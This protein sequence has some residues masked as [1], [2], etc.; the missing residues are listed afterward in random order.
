MLGHKVLKAHQECGDQVHLVVGDGMSEIVLP[1]Q[2]VEMKEDHLL[3][4]ARRIE[5]PSAVFLS[6][7]VQ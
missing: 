3:G 1:R 2:R 7:I 5:Y 6:L 4:L